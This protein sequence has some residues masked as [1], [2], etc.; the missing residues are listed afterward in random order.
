MRADAISESEIKEGLAT[1]ASGRWPWSTERRLDVLGLETDVRRIETLYQYRGYY[2]ARVVEHRAEPDGPDRVRVIFRVEEGAPT[3]ITQVAID[4]LE[5]FPP[6]TR[7]RI[8]RDLRLKRGEIIRVPEYE[9]TLALLQERLREV[10]HPAARV[11]GR[12]DV[13]P[14]ARQADVVFEVSPGPLHRYGDIAFEGLRAFPEAPLAAI[15]RRAA[16]R[17]AEYRPDDIEAA[18]DRLVDLRAFAGVR[19]AVEP[20]QQEGGESTLRVV[21]DE[22]PMHAL[23]LGGGVGVQQNV[24]Q[25]QLIAEYRQGNFLGGARRLVWRNEAALRFL[26]TFFTPTRVGLNAESSVELTQPELFHRTDLAVLTGYRRL[27]RQAFA[28]NVLNARVG[29]PRQLARTSH[30]TPALNFE[31]LFHL[32]TRG[33]IGPLPVSVP[34]TCPAPCQLAYVSLTLSHDR[35]DDALSPRSGFLL[36]ADAQYGFPLPNGG[37][38]YARFEP[39]ARGY[40]PVNR[41]LVLAGRARVGALLPLGGTTVSPLTQRFFGGGDGGHRGFGPEQ[42]SPLVQDTPDSF[43][44]VGGNGL[45][46]TSAEARFQPFRQVGFVTFADYGSVTASP[47]A[48]DPSAGY[49]ALGVGLR[50]Y[51]LA[52]PVRLD[53]AWRLAGPPRIVEDTGA[54]ADVRTLD[55]FTFFLSLGEAF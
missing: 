49:L 12:V 30:L 23:T 35:R 15:V 41:W 46:L 22:L 37:F 47:L 44:P 38:H 1:Q 2:G 25:L 31:R 19:I 9:E 18:E 11:D 32:E 40:L 52:G 27:F 36:L 20:P 39:E 55:Y 6:D 54:P 4:G 21:A 26:P 16:P 28:A 50:V 45:W 53:T 7:E 17:G 43:V 10:G 29:L 48:I 24:Q 3:R 13:H 34:N 33:P 42:L 51:T 5:V 14:D 8:T